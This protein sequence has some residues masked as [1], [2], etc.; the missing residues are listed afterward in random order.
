[1]AANQIQRLAAEFEALAL[2]RL[3]TKAEEALKL[4]KAT[5]GGYGDG[6]KRTFRSPVDGRMVG[7][8]HRTD[9]DPEWKVTDRKALEEH[10][11][12]FPGNLRSVIV[13]DEAEVMGVLLDHAPHLIGEELDPAV[14]QAA[15][16]QSKATN[17]PAAPGIT[18]EKPGGVLTVLPDKHQA[19]LAIQGLINAKLLTWDGRRSLPAAEQ[20]EAS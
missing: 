17:E 14:V 11:R 4:S 18:L 10:L 6:D 20:K 1:M 13:G 15:L 8:V 7:Q 16:N 19:D 12:T 3:A 5:L 9:P 2:R